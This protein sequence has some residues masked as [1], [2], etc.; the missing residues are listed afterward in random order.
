MHICLSH[1]LPAPLFSIQQWPIAPCHTILHLSGLK[2]NYHFNL[3]SA[4]VHAWVYLWLTEVLA[5]C[6]CVCLSVRTCVC[7]RGFWCVI[8]EA[9]LTPSQVF[10]LSQ[11]R[12]FFFFYLFFFLTTEF[13][14]RSVS[15]LQTTAFHKHDG[16]FVSGCLKVISSSFFFFFLTQFPPFISARRRNITCAA[17][18]K[19]GKVYNRRYNMTER[20]RILA[21]GQARLKFPDSLL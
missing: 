17:V 11:T 20:N 15:I 10:P 19:A 8:P 4:F 1:C 12:F 16:I 18:R 3:L 7:L 21:K 9:P 5:V 13:W 2:S 14:S 6:V